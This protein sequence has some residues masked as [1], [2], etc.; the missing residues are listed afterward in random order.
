MVNEYW[1]T[2]RGNTK[3]SMLTMLIGGK[4]YKTREE[5]VLSYNPVDTF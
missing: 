3:L 4:L 1:M 2:N 5:V